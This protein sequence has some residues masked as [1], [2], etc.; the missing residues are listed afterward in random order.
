[1]AKTAT[2]QTN[3]LKNPAKPLQGSFPRFSTPVWGQRA[4]PE[5]TTLNPFHIH[6]TRR[7]TMADSTHRAS[8]NSCL[9]RTCLKWSADGELSA[10]DF[11]LV[12]GRLAQVDHEVA[13]LPEPNL[14]L[15]ASPSSS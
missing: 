9:G 6:S 12:M 11:A 1:V 8:S 14:Q 13:V 15:R 4:A 3:V 2:K 10:L 7:T 5:S